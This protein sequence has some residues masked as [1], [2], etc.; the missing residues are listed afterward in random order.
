MALTTLDSSLLKQTVVSKSGDY[1]ATDNDDVILVTTAGSTITITLPAA[2]GR[3]GK[4]F[5]IKKVDSGTGKVVVDGNGAE[6]IDGLASVQIAFQY[7]TIHIVCDGSGWQFVGQHYQSFNQTAPTISNGGTSPS[8]F[9]KGVRIG[10]QVTVTAQVASGTGSPA[11]P[12]FA[13]GSIPADFAPTVA[14]HAWSEIFT[15]TDSWYKA[16]FNATGSCDFNR[17][18]LAGATDIA[19]VNW[20]VSTTNRF[21][22]SYIKY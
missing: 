12:S 18:N 8:G 15:S 20:P 19:G 1:T 21:T 4:V 5:N 6:T 11:S 13:A 7:E 2:S 3:T 14:C 10:R 17:Y 22:T 9:V 16:D